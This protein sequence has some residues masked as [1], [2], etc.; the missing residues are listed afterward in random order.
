MRKQPWFQNTSD[1][2]QCITKHVKVGSI[3]TV[4]INMCALICIHPYV[5]IYIQMTV[6]IKEDIVTLGGEGGVGGEEGEEG[7]V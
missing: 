1:W 7:M 4:Y 3:P 5:D 6:I 2:V